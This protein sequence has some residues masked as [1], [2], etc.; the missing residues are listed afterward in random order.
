MRIWTINFTL[1]KS[2]STGRFCLFCFSKN[3]NK[4]SDALQLE[5]TFYVYTF[6]NLFLNYRFFRV[7]RV[8]LGS[9]E[10]KFIHYTNLTIFYKYGAINTILYRE[11]S[12]E[13]VATKIKHFMFAIKFY[14]LNVECKQ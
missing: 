3:K 2:V 7:E 4:I 8:Q 9:N 6:F 11:F 13:F 5:H 1:I 14:M 10:E 12:F